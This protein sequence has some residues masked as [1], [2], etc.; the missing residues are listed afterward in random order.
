MTGAPFAARYEPTISAPCCAQFI[1]SRQQLRRRAYAF[2]LALY[3]KTVGGNGICH[4][5]PLDLQQLAITHQIPVPEHV[6]FGPEQVVDLGK[7]TLAGAIEHLSHVIFGFQPHL[8]K[9]PKTKDHCSNFHAA[10]VCPGSPCV[11]AVT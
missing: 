5:G 1:A 10:A 9:E 3:H 2:W 4:K 6:N 8:G 11:S 7:H